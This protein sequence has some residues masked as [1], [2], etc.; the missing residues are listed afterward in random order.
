MAQSQRPSQ[1]ISSQIFTLFLSECG[2]LSASVRAWATSISEISVI[3][4][5]SSTFSGVGGGR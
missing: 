2:V 1:A 5:R 4:R 3:L